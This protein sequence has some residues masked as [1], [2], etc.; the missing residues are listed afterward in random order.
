[1]QT[2]VAHFDGCH[3]AWTR[4]AHS[5]AR[6]AAQHPSGCLLSWGSPQAVAMAGL[7]TPAVPELV[8]AAAAVD[9]L[10]SAAHPE[11]ASVPHKSHV[12]RPDQ[13]AVARAALKPVGP[14]FALQHTR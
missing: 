5:P 3:H 11:P 12:Q 6:H 10:H 1:M 9:L 4:S 2:K 8:V 14:V 13:Q 7:C